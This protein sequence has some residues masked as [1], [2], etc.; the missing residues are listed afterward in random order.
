[1]ESINNMDKHAC[2][3]Y[4]EKKRRNETTNPCER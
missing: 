2:A 3:V 4:K 1:M